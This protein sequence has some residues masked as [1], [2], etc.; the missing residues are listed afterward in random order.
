MKKPDRSRDTIRNRPADFGHVPTTI[1]GR[2]K[3]MLDARMYSD[4]TKAVRLIQTHTSWVFLT[5][6]HAYKVK[7]PVNFGF[8]DYT[9]LAARKFFCAEEF[10]LNQCLSPDIYIAVMPI[11]ERRG[12][13][14]LGGPGKV[15]DYCLAMKELPQEWIMTEQLK[16]DRVKYEHMDAIAEAISRFHARA[17]RGREVAQYGSSEIVRLNWDENFSQTLEFRGKTIT[18]RQFEETKAAIDRFIDVNRGLFRR[19]REG[20][21]VR[22]CHGDLHSRN[23]FVDGGVHIF[24]CIEFN[25]RF[26][27]SDVAS[28]IA[29][30]VMDLEY[31]GRKDLASF[32]V[33]RYL[34]FTKDSGLLRLLDFYKCYRAYVRGKVTSFN[35][36]D[37]GMSPADKEAARRTAR[38]YF[39]LSH[40][41]A[42][43]LLAKPRLVV[44]MG[45]PGVGKT[46]VARKLAERIDAFHLLSDSI[47]RQLLGIPISSRRYEGYDRNI[48]RGN[49]GKKTYDEM[50][51]RAAM[52]LSSGH[53]VVMDA[54]FLHPDSRKRVEAVAARAK[55]PFLFVYAECPERIV[56]SRLRHR[57]IESSFSD[58]DLEVYRS[59]KSRFKPPRVTR[60]LI[61]VDTTNP[62]SVTLAKIERALL[63]S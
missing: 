58:A 23:V 21:F 24:D 46:Y 50:L 57:E 20:G 4:G 22:R 49:I 25:P 63:H 30:M 61:R 51:R 14:Y 60:H 3:E 41:Y 31:A 39:G 48:Y 59:M 33:E 43:R 32:F 53:S 29:F 18:F 40:R 2:V 16:H 5:G 52:F 7:K 19:R 9:T 35:L 38:K 45:L 54:T 37:P 17:E 15:I 36:N 26:S 55:V 27:C 28:E 44:T 13:L 56:K 34:V 42:R 12:K 47:R 8:L 10:R 6:T 62:L 11:V 1:Q